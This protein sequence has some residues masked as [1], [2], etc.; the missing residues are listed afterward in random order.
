MQL[1]RGKKV[2]KGNTLY[3]LRLMRVHHVN[4]ISA[5]RMPWPGF[6]GEKNYNNDRQVF[7]NNRVN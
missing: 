5:F 2:N 3:Y 7:F 4:R 6:G 1:L